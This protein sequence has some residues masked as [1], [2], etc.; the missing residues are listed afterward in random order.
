[1][2]VQNLGYQLMRLMP[3]DI[4]S[5]SNH[6][7]FLKSD[8]SQEPIHLNPFSAG[9]FKRLK[10]KKG[11]PI[12][13]VG[14][15]FSYL[16][17]MEFGFA[18]ADYVLNNGHYQTH[19]FIVP[20]DWFGLQGLGY[21]QYQSST[22][23]LTDCQLWAIDKRVLIAQMDQNAEIRETFEAIR[24]AVLSRS[25]RHCVVLSTYSVEQKLAYFLIDFQ[26]RLQAVNQHNPW[27]Q[28]PM[29][30]E[31]LKS[32]LGITTESLSRAFASLEKGGYL[33]VNN[34]MITDIDF[35]GLQQIVD[36]DS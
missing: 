19:R 23:A 27:I 12:F 20:G 30:R 7:Q 24:S 2:L 25:H 18:K 6:L 14:E 21:G 26:H 5:S 3:Q 10:L 28:L 9:L 31:D 16:F 36:S 1:M 8:S 34:R 29:S 22:T 13:R 4:G 35:E 32:Y 11:E 17:F 33:K 15:V